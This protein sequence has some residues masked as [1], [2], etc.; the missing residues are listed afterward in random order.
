MSERSM[1]IVLALETSRPRLHDRRADQHVEALLPEVEHDLLEGVLAHLA[2]GRGDARL[3]HELADPGGGLL[4]RL[5][6]VVD[7][8]H[9]ALAQQLAAHGRDDLA[10]LVGADVGEDRV[11][12]L[13]RRGDRR[14][15]ADAGDRHLEG[16][17]DRR[18]AHRQHVDRRAHPLHLLLVL[19]TEALLLV[20]D[21]QAE[22]L[23]LDVGVE[24]AVGADDDVDRP[25]AEAG[26]DLLGLLV[27]L[28]AREPLDRRPG[29]RSSARR[30][31][32]GAG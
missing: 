4:D 8:E 16:A 27:G 32:T 17:R 1:I 18:R 13:G 30:T 31:S 15:L 7:V 28:E 20:D 24:Q 19:D 6:P 25:V 26:D 11:P 29:S 23:D 10:V 2:V 9:L 22:V 3:G 12:L 5:H 21:D 14:H